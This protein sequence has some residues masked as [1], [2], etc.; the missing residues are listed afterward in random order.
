MR[1]EL[2]KD[3]ETGNPVIDRE[4]RELFQAVN[5]LMDSCSKGQGRAMILPAIQ[6]L[7]SY[8]DKHFSHEEQLQQSSGYP[9]IAAHRTFHKEYKK[10]LREI[11]AQIPEAGPS[12]ADLG[13]L[14]KHIALLVSHIRS[15]DKK[16]GA[17]LRQS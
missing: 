8:V 10:T 11:M 12:V 15:E 2:T 3:L 4:H 7:Q 9:G 13:R 5:Q 1:Y 6:F 16:L 14:N 17:F